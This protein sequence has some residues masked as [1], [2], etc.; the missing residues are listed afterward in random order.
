MRT[1]PIT[2]LIIL[3]TLA[4]KRPKAETVCRPAS[5]G[6]CLACVDCTACRHCAKNKE[7]CSICWKKALDPRPLDPR[8]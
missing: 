3:L 7:K 4:S 8:P 2:L 1:L 6:T 5:D